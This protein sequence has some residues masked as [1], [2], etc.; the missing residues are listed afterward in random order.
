MTFHGK[1]KLTSK[2]LDVLKNMPPLFHKIPGNDF[3]IKKSEIIEWALQQNDILDYLWSEV[4]NRSGNIVYDA[5]LQKWIGIDLTNGMNS[6]GEKYYKV[7]RIDE[8]DT[9]TYS[10]YL[11]EEKLKENGYIDNPRFIVKPLGS[12]EDLD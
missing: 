4:I 10:N 1:R 11:T 12:E 7:T 8:K 9:F 2:K 3:D 5:N 6:K